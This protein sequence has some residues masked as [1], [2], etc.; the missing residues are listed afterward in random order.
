MMDREE[1]VE[2]F[3]VWP[4]LVSIFDFWGLPLI[5]FNEIGS[6]IM[7]LSPL[8]H[9]LELDGIGRGDFISVSLLLELPLFVCS[10]YFIVGGCNPCEKL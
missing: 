5:K 8:R 2:S 4:F 1:K 10:L 3:K 9:F 6:C 7:F